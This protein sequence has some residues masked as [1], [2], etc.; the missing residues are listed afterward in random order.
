MELDC[1]DAATAPSGPLTGVLVAAVLA[2]SLAPAS[3]GE[4]GV[5]LISPR[6]NKPGLALPRS[7][8]LHAPD[9]S[10]AFWRL[11]RN[12]RLVLIQ[13]TLDFLFY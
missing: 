2:S 9:S 4:G 3:F 10:G 5:L 1:P 6:P 8:R 13:L 11:R 12:F 7:P